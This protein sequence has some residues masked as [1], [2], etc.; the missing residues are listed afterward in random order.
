M[1]AGRGYFGLI[2]LRENKNN[3]SKIIVILNNK[4][5]LLDHERFFLN[6]D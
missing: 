6:S 2:I 4:S 3:L 1:Y 5:K